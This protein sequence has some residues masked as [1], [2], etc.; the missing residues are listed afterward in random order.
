MTIKT[1]KYS[2]HGGLVTLS[3]SENDERITLYTDEY[4]ELGEHP[5]GHEISDTEYELYRAAA[6]YCIAVK[7]A[8]KL[9][10]YSDNSRVNLINKLRHAGFSYRTAA[11]AADRMTELGYIDESAQLQRLITSLA[12]GGLFGPYKIVQR[13][14][15]KGYPTSDIQKVLG[16]LTDIGEIDFRENLG[17]LIKK[18]LGDTSDPELCEKLKY[19][20]GYKK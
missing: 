8:L 4:K 16:R 15:A 7:R 14:C 20:Y 3:F 10:S 12:N 2:E 5:V 1:L 6:D 17:Q 9:L 13:L 19:K 11:R 18:K